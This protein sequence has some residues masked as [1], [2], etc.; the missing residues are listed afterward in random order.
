[1][2][3]TASSFADQTAVSNN[4]PDDSPFSAISDAAIE[5]ARIRSRLDALADRLVGQIPE[6]NPPAMSSVESGLLG[7]VKENAR[8]ITSAVAGMDA[9]IDR[10]F[11]HL[12]PDAKN[13]LAAG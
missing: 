1:M 6:K 9:A 13:V 5:V 12:P 11:A 2:Y 7:G 10:V 8:T 3:A 4:L